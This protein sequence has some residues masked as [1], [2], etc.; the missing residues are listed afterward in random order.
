MRL[1]ETL[2]EASAESSISSSED[3]H[4]SPPASPGSEAEPLMIGGSGLSFCA[5]CVKSIPC[6]CWRRTLAE[7]FLSTLREW[8]FVNGSRFSLRI[9]DTR[10]CQSFLLLQTSGHPTNANESGL[11][12]TPTVSGNH[13]R[14]GASEKSGDGLATAVKR[15]PS[16][17][18]TDA[19]KGGPNPRGSKGDLMLPSAVAKWASPIAGDA[20]GSRTSKGKDR[21]NECGLAGQVKKWSTPLAADWRS[22]HASE[23]TMESNCRPLREQVGQWAKD[24]TSGTGR[25]PESFHL[26][27]RWELQLMGMPADWLDGVE[28]E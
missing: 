5:W 12:P 27:P 19:E 28:P 3:R 20:D 17:R 7:S 4:A 25:S 26:N 23:E 16:P 10:S 24:S 11:W 9:S 6:G 1:Q 18:A 21:P 8:G 13:N 15:W 22:I 14:A 2:F